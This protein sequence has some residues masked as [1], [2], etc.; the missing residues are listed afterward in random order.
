M[1]D[2]PEKPDKVGG[3]ID[4]EDQGPTPIETRDARLFTPDD[5]SSLNTAPEA[6][7][8]GERLPNVDEYSN[9][10]LE[11]IPIKGLRALLIAVAAVFTALVGWEVYS[12]IAEL[13]ATHW[14]LA[15]AFLGLLGTTFVLGLR[16]LKNYRSD[17]GS[18]DALQGIQEHA[19]QL[20][21]SRGV[22]GAQHLLISLRAF[23]ADKPQAAYLKRCLD[24]L[25]DYSDDMEVVAHIDRVF[26]GPLD[27][28]AERRISAHSLQTGTAIALSPWATLD[29]ALVFWR[30]LKMIEDVAQVYGVRP[31]L[32]NRARVLKMVATH[33]VYVGG[34][35]LAMDH[36]MQRFAT[37]GVAVPVFSAFA[38]GLGAGI[39]TAKIGVAAIQVTRPITL[40]ESERPAVSKLI[41]PMLAELKLQFSKMASSESEQ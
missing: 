3:L 7:T 2:L 21:Q 25:P 29:I 32:R 39:Y 12:V 38:Q 33:A 19:D 30:N 11:A 34:S 8:A 1:S 13:R 35:Q 14:V 9:I 22:D 37:G 26:L 27:K 15:A 20:R 36:L 40:C 41:M 23:Y 4:I 18:L 17:S 28:E 31:T 5:S 6:I 24:S 10:R 16:L